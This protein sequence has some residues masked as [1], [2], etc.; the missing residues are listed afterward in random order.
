MEVC[1]FFDKCRLFSCLRS[2]ASKRLFEDMYCRKDCAK[3]A[4]RIL[5]REG[6]KLED[7]PDSLLPTG[8]HLLNHGI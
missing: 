1:E 2:P 4:R 7:I 6:M 5:S 8:G 3:C